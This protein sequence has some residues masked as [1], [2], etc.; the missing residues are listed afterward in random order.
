MWKEYA[1]QD[2]PLVKEEKDKLK[3]GLPQLKVYMR[4]AA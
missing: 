2:F 3:S 4:K 1:V